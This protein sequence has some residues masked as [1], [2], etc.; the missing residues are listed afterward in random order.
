[1]KIILMLLLVVGISP[2]ANASPNNG[3]VDPNHEL[4]CN[5]MHEE[6]GS[7]VSMNKFTESFAL[8]MVTT[9]T[10]STVVIPRTKSPLDFALCASCLMQPTAPSLC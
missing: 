3:Q 7:G 6:I 8:R 2:L 4:I 1:M 9:F 5:P 10:I